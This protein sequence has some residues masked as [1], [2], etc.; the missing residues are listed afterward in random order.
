LSE[1]AADADPF[2]EFWLGWEHLQQNLRRSTAV[3]VNAAGLREEARALVQMYFRRVRPGLLHVVGEDELRSL[4]DGMQDLLRLAQGKN[5]RTSYLGAMNRIGKDRTRLSIGRER[6]FTSL[7]QKT[8][9]AGG[10]SASQTRIL[11]TL[12]SMLPDAAASYEQAHLD[13]CGERV[14]YRG[15]AVE[16]REVV[17][18]T[19]DHLAPDEAVVREAAFKLEKDRVG[20]TMRQKAQFILRSR[21][22]SATARKAPQDAVSIVDELTASFV[23]STYERGSASTHS[24]T[25]R[26]DVERLRA[27]VDTVLMELLEAF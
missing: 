21:G 12:Q 14:S 6:G 27:Y 17:R 19:L 2:D 10:L 23:R 5:A 26:Q 9:Q 11:R 20:P 8:G 22:L 7:S 25:T 3:N 15:T 24:K 4:D 13:L 16:L 18:E 1:V